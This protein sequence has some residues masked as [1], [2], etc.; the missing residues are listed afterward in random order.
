[1]DWDCSSTKYV[2]ECL[3]TCAC[4]TDNACVEICMCV[5]GFAAASSSEGLSVCHLAAQED[6]E[7]EEAR[8]SFPL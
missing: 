4:D 6:E 8:E 7:H 5:C 1:M 2:F 3:C